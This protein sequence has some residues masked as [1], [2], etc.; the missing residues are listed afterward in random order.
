MTSQK[1]RP[2]YTRIYP[3][4]VELRFFEAING[5]VYERIQRVDH[6]SLNRKVKHMYSRVALQGE[7]A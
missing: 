3:Y 7:C 1:S 4:S 5:T 2:R 6:I